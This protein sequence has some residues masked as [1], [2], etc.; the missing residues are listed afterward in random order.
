MMV[1]LMIVII[2]PLEPLGRHGRRDEGDLD[3][4]VRR[5]QA[6]LL[7]QSRP[8]HDIGLLVT[9][10]GGEALTEKTA[11]DDDGEP[12]GFVVDD[13]RQRGP[14]LPEGRGERH[15]AHIGLEAGGR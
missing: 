9:I 2:P 6:K 1:V 15:A 14:G 5:S 10:K 4:G 8:G 3:L 12:N 11:T 13:Q 7:D